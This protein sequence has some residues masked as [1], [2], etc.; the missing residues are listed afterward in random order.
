MFELFKRKK[1]N[2]ILSPLDGKC[3]DISEVKDR[4]FADKLLGDGIAILPSSAVVRAPIDGE[5]KM[6]FPTKHAFG[7]KGDDGLEILIHIGINTVELDGKGFVALKNVNDKVKA[8]DQVII[9]DKLYLNNKDMTTMVILTL[10]SNGYKKI[11]I[12]QDV[13]CKEVIMQNETS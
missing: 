2:D 4:T 12:G 10:S 1:R 9:F 3:I 11:K 13:K 5:I 6:I 7:I 8:G